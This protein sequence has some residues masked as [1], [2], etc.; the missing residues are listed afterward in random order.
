MVIPSIF[1]NKCT[2]PRSMNACGRK[3][4][5]HNAVKPAH[6]VTCIKRSPLG[7]RKGLG[8]R[9]IVLNATFNNISVTSWRSVLLVEEDRVLRENHRPATSHTKKKWP[10]KTVDLLKE[11]QCI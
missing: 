2:V 9:A 5:E 7:C 4:C 11:V 10:Y 6:A 1:T 8:V 3:K